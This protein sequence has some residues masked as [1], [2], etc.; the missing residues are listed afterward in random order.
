[1]GELGCQSC[2]RETDQLTAVVGR[3][4]LCE[5]C[6]RFAN[7]APLATVLDHLL[8]EP[9]PGLLG[10][11]PPARRVLLNRPGHTVEAD[12][13]ETPPRGGMGE[14]LT[15][16]GMDEA[17]VAETTWTSE[18]TADPITDI[19]ELAKAMREAAPPAPA[20]FVPAWAWAWICQE[21]PELVDSMQ[22]TEVTTWYS[23]AAFG[24]PL[25]LQR[26]VIA[27]TVEGRDA[28]RLTAWLLAR[29]HAGGVP[30]SE[31]EEE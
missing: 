16:A 12:V 14:L 3:G 2:G 7:Q 24:D 11:P 23:A 6:A 15:A 29:W 31:A 8:R 5:V 4:L 30:W 19:A 25:D 10:T 22:A 27:Y 17:T 21:D 1:M 13:Y 18:A 26:R 20:L 28:D 9:L